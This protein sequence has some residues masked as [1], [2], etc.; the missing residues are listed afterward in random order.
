MIGKSLLST[1]L[2]VLLSLALLAC[3]ADSPPQPHNLEVSPELLRRHIEYLA[4]DELRGRDTGS[5]GYNKAAAYVAEQFESLGLKP[6]GDPGSF[7]QQVPLVEQRLVKGSASA[8][9]HGPGGK[10]ALEYPAQFIMGADRMHPTSVLNAE[11][12]FVGYGIVAEEF[13]HD[14]YAGLDVAGKAV[15]MLG[16]RPESWPSEEG[17][18]LGSSREKARHASERGAVGIVSLNTPRQELTFPW[19]DNY[20]YLEVPGMDW[21]SPD[22]IPDGYFPQLQAG[23]FLNTDAAALVFEGAPVSLGDIFAA[24]GEGGD[25]I[26][27]FELQ[28]S[29]NLRRESTH[30]HFSSPNV[31]AILEGS[32]PALRDEFLVYTAHLDHLGVIKNEEGVEEIYN[33]AM[34]N[35]AGVATLIETAR[36][37]AAERDR[38]KRSVLFVVVTGEEKGLLGAGYYAKN[39]TVPIEKMVANINLDMPLFTYPFADVVAFGAEHSTLKALVEKAANQADIALAPDPMP[40]QVLFVRS[41]HYRFV[42]QGVPAVFLVTG[43]TSK[44][45]EPTGGEVFSAHLRDHYHQPSDDLNLAIDYQAGA[46]FTEINI[47]IGREVCNSEDRPRWNEGDFFG[48][49]F[50]GD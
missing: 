8:T 28:T 32:D 46:L 22:G 50:A 18:R 45:G 21:V 11:L 10:T 34:D 20:Q 30:R 31:V 47:N 9:V 27:G 40:E 15:V 19:D 44:N 38:L 35:A 7:L 4:A 23:V 26:R 17:A 41:D 1:T 29:I 39:P 24:D 3:Q 37:L 25:D 42:Q 16:G 49:T 33:G 13:D 43:F 6:A 5:P 12:V 2:W 48:E 36:V 14:D